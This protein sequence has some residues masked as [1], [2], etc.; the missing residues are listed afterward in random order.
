MGFS[1]LIDI[2]GSM[3]IGGMLMLILFRL[4]D[5][6]TK[7]SYNY[8]GEAIV[9]QNLVEVVQLIEHD[10]RKIGYCRD[11][12]QIPDPSK[13]ILTADSTSISYLTD[14]DDDGTMDSLRYFLGPKSELTETPNP[15]DRM[16]YR[17]E[18][19]ETPISAN[20]GVTQFSLEFY[21][22]LS[23]KLDFPIENPGQIY[24]MRIDLKVENTSA[25]DQEYTSAFWRQIR[26]VARN[27][28]NR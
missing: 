10:F 2:V 16:L 19:G 3:V 25:Y 23:N 6:A 12:S 22:A 4:Q 9:Q 5:N 14:L 15:N 7:N 8:G 26:L 17:V 21:D 18:N 27:L 1:T 13:A 11:W 28:R 24:T 20:L